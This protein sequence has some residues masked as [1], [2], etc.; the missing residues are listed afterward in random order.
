M[1]TQ[2]TETIHRIALLILD[3]VLSVL[4]F[5]FVSGETEFCPHPTKET[6]PIMTVNEAFEAYRSKKA[7]L[8]QTDAKVVTDQNSVT[9]AKSALAAADAQLA[10][11]QQADLAAKD[12]VVTSLKSIQEAVQAELQDLGKQLPV[13]VSTAT[14]S[15]NSK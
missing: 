14:G 8:E 5:P 13:T 1:F 10:T 7:L 11:S 3:T 15:V 12:D 9:Q 4:A 2:L 6:Y